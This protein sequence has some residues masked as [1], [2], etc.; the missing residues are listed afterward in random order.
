VNKTL[1]ILISFVLLLNGVFAQEGG[2]YLIRNYPTTETN[3]TAQTWGAMEDDRGV[4]YF[5]AG[6]KVIKYHG[7]HWTSFGLKGLVAP[8][9]MA[10]SDDGTIFIGGESEFGKMVVDSLGDIGYKSLV[11]SIPESLKSFGPVWSI[12]TS[13]DKVYFSSNLAVFVYEAGK[14][15]PLPHK[16]FPILFK[17]DERVYFNVRDTGLHYIEEGK[18]SFAKGGEKFARN[19]VQGAVRLNEK[20]VMLITGNEGIASYNPVTGAVNESSHPLFDHAPQFRKDYIY[21]STETI[22]GKVAIGTIYAGLYLF[23]KS[24]VLENKI[25]KSKGLIDNAINRMYSDR[26]G[27]LWLGTDKGI[28]MI[29]LNNGIKHWDDRHGINGFVEDIEEYKGELYIGTSTHIRYNDKGV[30]KEVEGVKA[31]TWHLFKHSEDRFFA[32]NTGGLLEIVD[33]KAKLL[34]NKVVCYYLL[35][36]NKD[37]LIIAGKEGLM[38]FSLITNKL[39]TLFATKS[40]VRAIA[41]GNNGEIWF[42]T[43]NHG[44]GKQNP[45]GSF[46]MLS[47]EKGLPTPNL[48]AVFNF[49]DK[50]YIA[51]KYGLYEYDN[52][53]DSIVQSCDLG[54]YLCKD[55]VG[56]FRFEGGLNGDYWSSIYGNASLRLNHNVKNGSVYNRDTAFLKRIPRKHSFSFYPTKTGA[57]FSNALGLYKYDRSAIVDV[58]R[59]YESLISYVQIGQDSIIFNGSYAGK[60]KVYTSEQ[61]SSLI[62]RL[63]FEDNELTFHYSTAYYIEDKQIYH[64]YQLEGFDE[65]WSNFNQD[66]KK[67]YTNLHEG[68]YKFKVRAKNVYGELSKEASYEFVILPPWYRTWYAYVTYF[69]FSSAFIYLLIWLNGK[70]LRAAN[71]KLEGIVEERTAEVVKQKEEIEVKNEMITKSITYAKTIQ[72]AIL[73]SAEFFSDNFHDH[74][75]LYKPK[76]IVSGDFYWAYKTKSNKLLWVAAD[77]TGHGVPGAFMTMIG[78]SLLNEIVIERGIEDTDVILNELRD[79]VIKT[80]NKEIDSE[81]DK[82]MRNGMDLALCCW[83]LETNMLTFSGAGNPVFIIR[84]NEL[85]TIKGDRQPIGLHK[86]MKPFTKHEYQLMDGDK[87]YTFS[88]G[89]SDQMGGENEDR[90]KLKNFKAELKQ[91]HTNKLDSQ[92]EHLDKYFENW[93]GNMEQMDD[94]VVIGVEIKF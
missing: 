80:L 90:I 33:H 47:V 36:W 83:D 85:E 20:V 50:H 15:R 14:V 37:T 73:T 64:Q 9:S 6:R 82:K 58:D 45:D 12:V 91:I 31:S 52:E 3:A 24:G 60:E 23:S 11:D 17:I 10:K 63:S 29:E 62:P 78:N 77:C 35:E 19:S 30:F 46:S 5:P 65:Q 41:K 54:A 48:N 76:D 66:F 72:E 25:D 13:G 22:D 34:S 92:M 28:A 84:D 61:P 75:L 16:P 8:I 2:N 81:D 88:D 68:K 7:K 4:M 49:N 79:Q 21:C 89:Y 51:T 74:F 86:K 56:L 40:S 26:L 38:Q 53:K 1:V 39:E 70:R 44:L 27:N 59:S 87:L 57:Y 69:I 32:A 55:S 43:Q 18:V 42:S 71:I 93:K 94:V 67:N